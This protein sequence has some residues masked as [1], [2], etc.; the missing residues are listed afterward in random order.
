MCAS[1][2]NAWDTDHSRVHCTLGINRYWKGQEEQALN[3]PSWV[4]EGNEPCGN[5][6]DSI[7]VDGHFSGYLDGGWDS[8]YTEAIRA[9]FAEPDG[10]L[11]KA[12]EQLS[13]GRHFIE[14]GS[15]KA[16]ENDYAHFKEVANRFGLELVSFGG[17]SQIK[18]SGSSVQDDDDFIKFHLAVTRGE[19]IYS[20]HMQNLN[21]WKDAGG[22]LFVY[23]VDF[24]RAANSAHAPLEHLQQS[25]SPQWNAITEFNQANECWWDGCL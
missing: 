1:W 16:L 6:V 4:S 3:C 10:G 24:E 2:K 14:K 12:Y 18:S 22:S 15:I 8:A 25:S 9:W 11:S 20:I 7:G 13:D 5:F 19:G 23:S 17:G 21:A